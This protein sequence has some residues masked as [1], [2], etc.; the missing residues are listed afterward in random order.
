MSVEDNLAPKLAY[1]ERE[2]GLSRPE[3]RDHVLRIPAIFAYSLDKRFRPRVEASRAAGVD[4]T[5]VLTNIPL[6][7]EKFYKRLE[8]R[9]RAQV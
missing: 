5:Y 4:A 7:D 3:L 2:I 6:T 1:L 8:R 9:G